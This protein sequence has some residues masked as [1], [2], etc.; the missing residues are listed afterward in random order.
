MSREISDVYKR[1][2]WGLLEIDNAFYYFGDSDKNCA[3]VTGRCSF[4]DGTDNRKSIYRFD[5]SGK[6]VT[7]IKDGYFYYN[8]KLQKADPA[9]RCV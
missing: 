3:G 5:S 1:Q 4:A 8:G 9:A 6:G 2:A 7:G